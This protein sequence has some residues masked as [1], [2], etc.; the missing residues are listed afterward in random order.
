MNNK[1][2]IKTTKA[3]SAIGTYSQAVQC[4]DL[5]FVSGQIPLDP[6]TGEVVSDDAREQIEQSFKNLIAIAEAAGQTAN[7]FIKLSVYLTDLANF[8]LVNEIMQQHFTDPF[9]ARAAI[10]VASL[11]K[12]VAVEVEGIL[13]LNG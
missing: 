13:S 2:T 12:G 1:K 8:P 10:G 5:L 4:G 7:Q 11:P 3:P 9:P 6:A